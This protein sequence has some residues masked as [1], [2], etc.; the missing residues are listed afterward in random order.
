MIEQIHKF[1]E[2]NNLSIS[3]FRGY[4]SLISY[5]RYN[6]GLN[7]IH[8]CT[9]HGDVE[10]LITDNYGKVIMEPK[11]YLY[12]GEFIYNEIGGIEPTLVEC[13]K[14]LKLKKNETNKLS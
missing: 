11:I 8:N 7:I 2:D 13:I 9:S 1:I 4:G 12:Y 14:Y 6:H 10:F 5:F 3:I